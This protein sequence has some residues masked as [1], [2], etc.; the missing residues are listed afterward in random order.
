MTDYLARIA[1]DQ[2]PIEAIEAI[3]EATVHKERIVFGL[4]K[5]AGIPSRWMAADVDTRQAMD[6]MIGCGWMQVAGEMARLTPDGM[7]F[8][9]SVAV[10]LM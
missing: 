1:R 9:D 10:A 7:L 5:S 8:A 3:D 6:R 2:L 4:R